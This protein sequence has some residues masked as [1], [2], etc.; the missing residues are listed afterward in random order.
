MANDK[1]YHRAVPYLS[2]CHL[3]FVMRTSL[4]RVRLSSTDVVGVKPDLDSNYPRRNISNAPGRAAYAYARFANAGPAR[5]GRESIGC[6][7][8]R[9]ACWWR[10]VLPQW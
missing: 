1:L 5:V 4:R 8:T 10:K 6:P 7:L 2:S 9:T 3:L